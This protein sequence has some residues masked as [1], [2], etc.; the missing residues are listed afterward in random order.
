[1]TVT[2]VEGPL[3]RDLRAIA[4]GRQALPESKG[5]RHHFVPAFLLAAFAEPP[6]QRKG[7][8]FQLDV[9]T[10]RPQRTKP[11]SAAFEKDLYA[12]EGDD[13]GDRSLEAFFS[14]V[15]KHTAPALKRLADS[16]LALTAEDRQTIAYFLSL[17]Q[18]RTPAALSSTI[19]NSQAAMEL[20]LSVQ[21]EDAASFAKTYREAVND[22]AS[23]QQIENFRE[24]MKDGL[25]NGEVSLAEPRS[26]ALQL[27]LHTSAP[28]AETVASLR[29]TLV[30]SE[31]QQFVTS[32]RG[33]AMHDP[34]PPFPWT[35]HAWRSSPNAQ[36]TVP[37]GPWRCLLVEAGPAG[38]GVD[39]ASPSTVREV[40]LRTYGWAKRFVYGRTQSVVSD[41]RRDAKRKP[42]MVTRPKRT[43]QVLVEEADPSDP[44]VGAENVRRGWPKGYWEEDDDGNRRFMA[45]TVI[46]PSDRSTI[47]SALT[48]GQAAQRALANRKL[49]RER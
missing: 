13:L 38:M 35:G 7:W 36:T 18:S 11:D 30:S 12:G 6:G 24:R 22:E 15:E 41:L 46:D 49:G 29:W 17:Q 5:R 9:R 39:I 1:M 19:E 32:D 4:E 10:G 43:K 44:T 16:P 21:F 34:T 27:L 48:G 31:T 28:I 42:R 20:F 3:A 45:Y 26:Q 14:L 37:L 47:S 40:N 33:I 8:M 25:V 23:D 2:A